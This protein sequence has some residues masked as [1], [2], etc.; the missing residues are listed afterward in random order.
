MFF[1]Q[2]RCVLCTSEDIFKVPSIQVQHKRSE[3]QKN[4]PGK[5][6]DKYIKDAKEEIRKEKRKLSNEEI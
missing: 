2:D 5:I 1:E 4:K 6:V 3:A